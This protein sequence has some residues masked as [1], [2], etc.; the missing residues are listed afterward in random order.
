MLEILKANSSEE[1]NQIFGQIK[2]R[3]EDGIQSRLA[4]IL[5]ETMGSGGWKHN[6]CIYKRIKIHQQTGIHMSSK[7]R[8]DFGKKMQANKRS[9]KL[10]NYPK[11]QPVKES[12]AL[13][14][15]AKIDMMMTTLK[16]KLKSAR[17]H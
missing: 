14:K 17:S 15:K 7:D 8:S 11:E 6:E 3:N 9:D 12:N 10:E 5:S 2:M 16:W 4:R 1:I 13:Q